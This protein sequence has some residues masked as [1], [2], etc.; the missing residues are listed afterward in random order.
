MG[1]KIINYA[2]AILDD[3]DTCLDIN[4][5]GYGIETEH[6]K[7]LKNSVYYD[8]PV[9]KHKS[10]RIYTIRSP[11]DIHL[12]V[13]VESKSLNSD[14]LNQKQFDEYLSGTFIDDKNSWC[15]VEKTTIQILIPQFLFWTKEKNIWIEQRP[16]P[17][18]SHNN[19]FVAIGGWFNMSNWTRPLSFSFDVVDTDNPIIIRRGD[20]LYQV[21]F[22]S[23]NLDDGFILK[24]SKPSKNVLRKMRNFTSIKFLFW[25]G[26]PQ[27]IKN[28]LFKNEKSKCP[29]KF[30][31]R[32]PI[33]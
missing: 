11:I 21:C 33:S 16:H 4:E 24:K 26:I 2:Q 15:T 30:L 3:Y 25:E 27:S 23:S 32:F 5:I 1:N 19:N 22:Y 20:P 10:N 28:K 18:T 31:N 12:S 14:T 17:L 6:S 7:T 9:W 13:D 29:F 8:C